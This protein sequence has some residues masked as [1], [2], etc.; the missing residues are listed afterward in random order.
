MGYAMLVTLAFDDIGGGSLGEVLDIL[1]GGIENAFDRFSRVK[2][3]M[4]R[5]DNARM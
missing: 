1:D 4:G 5:H 2:C 3:E